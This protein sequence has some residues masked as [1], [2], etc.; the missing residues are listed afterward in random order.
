MTTFPISP[1]AQVAALY[2]LA[3]IWNAIWLTGRVIS[4]GAYHHIIWTI[5][6]LLIPPVFLYLAVRLTFRE[7]QY[8]SQHSFAFYG[9]L[10]VAFLPFIGFLILI[11]CLRP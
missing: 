11:I 7:R 10:G 2:V 3:G 9:A 4:K 5:L 6:F 8:L 1:R